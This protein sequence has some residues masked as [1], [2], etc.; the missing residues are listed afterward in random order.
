MIVYK[1]MTLFLFNILSSLFILNTYNNTIISNV[2]TEI[3]SDFTTKLQ[4]VDDDIKT[5]KEDLKDC[6][7]MLNSYIRMNHEVSNDK[8]DI[9]NDIDIIKEQVINIKNQTDNLNTLIENL[10]KIS[11][12]KEKEIDDFIKTHYSVM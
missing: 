5:L 11:I 6:M 9:S 1:H 8:D 3:K 2:K 10:K 12:E 4:S 7:D